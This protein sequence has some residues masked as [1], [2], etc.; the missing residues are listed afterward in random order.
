MVLIY[1]CRINLIALTLGASYTIQNAKKFSDQEN[2][3]N[4]TVSI[5][6][7]TFIGI[8][9]WHLL[10]RLRNNERS[11]NKTNQFFASVSS[12]FLYLKLRIKKESVVERKE[13]SSCARDMG[14]TG[15]LQSVRYVSGPSEPFTA[16]TVISLQDMAAAPDSGQSRQPSPSQLR[17]PVLDFLEK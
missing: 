12:V 9:L 7:I 3:V 13:E 8:V 15:V 2:L 14:A 6:Y 10:K 11:R 5:T 1:Y 17:E 4:A 16:S